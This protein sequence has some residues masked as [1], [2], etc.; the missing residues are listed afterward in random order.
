METPPDPRRFSE[1]EL[2]E[3]WPK[4]S[5]DLRSLEWLLCIDYLITAQQ[6]RVARRF[7]WRAFARLTGQTIPDAAWNDHGMYTVWDQ[8][9]AQLADSLAGNEDPRLNDGQL[10]VAL[11]LADQEVAIR[12]GTPTT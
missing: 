4:T 11:Q 8:L 1:A 7:A 9:R 3:K 5:Q 6:L 10:E 2:I 12:A